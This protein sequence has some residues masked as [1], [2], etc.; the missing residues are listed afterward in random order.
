MNAQYPHPR[1][2]RSRRGKLFRRYLN[3][4]CRDSRDLRFRGPLSPAVGSHTPGRT[5]QRMPWL[6]PEWERAL[7]SPWREFPAR[8]T[9]Q[10]TGDHRTPPTQS[11]GEPA[12]LW[13]KNAF[14][15]SDWHLPGGTDWLVRPEW[16]EQLPERTAIPSPGCHPRHR[17]AELDIA[18]ELAPRLH[19]C[20]C[21]IAALSRHFPFFFVGTG[22]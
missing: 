18:A 13:S 7:P 8:P 19:S 10:S 1:V 22:C 16:Q 15:Y 20:S 11:E 12:A 3:T 5:P 2:L 21:T 14:P 4:S 6:L 17:T 9:L